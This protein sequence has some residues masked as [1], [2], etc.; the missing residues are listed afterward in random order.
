M[1]K[2]ML[3]I[4]VIGLLLSMALALSTR[5]A[6][7]RLR[8]CMKPRAYGYCRGSESRWFYNST[9]NNCNSF[10]YSGCGGNINRFTSRSE[11]HD[12]CMHQDI[13]YDRK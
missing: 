6:A 8:N 9:D 11:C 3:N 12:Y 4:V 10:I 1:V 13:P 7:E 2:L 5:D